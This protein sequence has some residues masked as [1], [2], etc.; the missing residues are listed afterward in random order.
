MKPTCTY[1][2][3]LI[4]PDLYRHS[5]H[6]RNWSGVYVYICVN[7]IKIDTISKI[8]ISTGARLFSL[9]ALFLAWSDI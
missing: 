1:S 6:G 5:L 4:T 3:I 2:T 8:G 7:S 9:L